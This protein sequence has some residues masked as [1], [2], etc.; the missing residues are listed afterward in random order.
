MDALG[1]LARTRNTATLSNMPIM[2]EQGPVTR[3]REKTN[4]T[5]LKTSLPIL[6]ETG[7]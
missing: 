5:K 1:I 6:L 3:L 7:R 2:W 4:L